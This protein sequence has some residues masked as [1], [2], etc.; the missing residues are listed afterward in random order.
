MPLFFI[1]LILL[2]AAC[3]R[4]PVI[5]PGYP[6][7]SSGVDEADS[8]LVEF[9]RLRGDLHSTRA[10]KERVVERFCSVA[11]QHPENSALQARAFYLQICGLLSNHPDSARLLLERQLADVDSVSLPYEWHSLQALRLPGEKSLFNRYMIASRNVDF[12]KSRG[13]EVEMARNLM[14]KAN[15]LSVMN[16]TA[17]A[18]ESLD[19]AEDIFARHGQPYGAYSAKVNRLPLY[20]AAERAQALKTLLADTALQNVPGLYVPLLQTAFYVTDSIELL[21]R[22]ISLVEIAS[23][24][25]DVRPVLL[26]MKGGWLARNDKPAEAMAML[27]AIKDAERYLQPVTFHRQ[28]IHE[29]LAMIYEVNGLMDSALHEMEQARWWADSLQRESNYKGVYARE[30][31]LRI[32]TAEQNARLERH[33]LVLWW[34]LALIAVAGA[35]GL[36]YMKARRAADRREAELRLLDEKIEAEQKVNLAQSSVLEESE[37]MISDIGTELDALVSKGALTRDGRDEMTRKMKAYR[38][39]D[40]SRRSFLKI[41]R[42]V[43]NAFTHRLKA[44]FPDLAESQLRLAALIATGVDSQQLASILNISPK[45]IYTSRYRLR[46]RLGLP[47][48]ASLE[49]F[50]RRYAHPT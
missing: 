29:D 34:V 3:S 1:L 39:N 42:E 4:T 14:L 16:D 24:Q 46:T 48:D 10:S 15:M 26:A 38:N 44:D 13:A 7:P 25:S 8:L 50:L 36:V 20:S 23:Q 40:E 2:I 6:W 28:A 18:L 17:R 49:D 9:E 41:N 35:G 21:D 33:Q 19:R 32:E 47:K 31:R 5:D 45:S 12:F 37:R 43:D 11:A 22:A 30:A 27:P